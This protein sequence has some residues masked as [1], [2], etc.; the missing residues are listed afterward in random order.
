MTIKEQIYKKI[1]DLGQVSFI[2]LEEIEG[3][4]GEFSLEIKNNKIVLWSGLSQEA[5]DSILELEKEKKIEASATTRFVYAIDG[6]GLNLP[7]V[8]SKRKYLKPHWLP[9]VYNALK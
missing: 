7:I 2:N 5:I 3:F 6:G 8:K 1:K 9:V 4:K